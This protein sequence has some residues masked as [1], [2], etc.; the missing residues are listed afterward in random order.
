MFFLLK[1]S[2]LFGNKQREAI[3]S[4][5]KVK[6]RYTNTTYNENTNTM[7]RYK[8]NTGETVTRVK[9]QGQKA[10]QRLLEG[11]NK[12]AKVLIN[13][14]SLATGRMEFK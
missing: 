8:Q 11:K 10:Q 2:C 4:K 5:V 3:L 14:R 13:V 9:V 6:E 12:K 7:E 1:Q